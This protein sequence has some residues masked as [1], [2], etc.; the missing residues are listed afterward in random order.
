MFTTAKTPTITKE[1]IAKEVLVGRY[2][3]DKRLAQVIIEMKDVVGAMAGV[4]TIMASLKVDMRQSVT[5]S[6][7]DGTAVYNAFVVFKDPSV[8]TG[9]LVQKLVHSPLVLNAR[10]IEG[11]QGAV[12]DTATFPVNWQ[13]RRVVI[14]AQPAMARMLE[15]VRRTFGS[16]GDVVLYQEGTDYGKD[17]AKFFIGMFG[18]EFLLVNY[19][20]GVNILA[21]TGWGIPEI[22]DTKNGFPD[23]TVRLSSC[24]ECTGVEQGRVACSFVR[25]VLA[26]VFSTIAESPLQCEELYCHGRGA[27][28]CEFRLNRATAASRPPA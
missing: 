27:P 21:S 1:Q 9:Q 3:P 26:G 16:G 13:G 2:E 25:G 28:Y 8:T 20:Y 6:L 15:S 14:L 23:L 7:P 24:L 19:D 18:R 10:V 5:H 22:V 4:A 17:L 11:R 12:L